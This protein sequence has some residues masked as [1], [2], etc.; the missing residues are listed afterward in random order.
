MLLLFLFLRLAR[1][2]EKRHLRSREDFRCDNQIRIADV[3]REIS[4]RA[5]LELTLSPRAAAAVVPKRSTISWLF[6]YCGAHID[7]GWR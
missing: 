2:A 1:H 7:V 4:G 6:E 3:C 5:T